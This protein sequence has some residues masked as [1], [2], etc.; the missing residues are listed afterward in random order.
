MEINKMHQTGT[1][2]ITCLPGWLCSK[3]NTMYTREGGRGK[4]GQAEVFV[5]VISLL[6]LC[7]IS[8]FFCFVFVLFSHGYL[9]HPL[10]LRRG[11]VLFEP[12]CPSV[13]SGKYS[14]GIKPKPQASTPWNNSLCH[15][16]EICH[17]NLLNF[18]TDWQRDKSSGPDAMCLFWVM[19]SRLWWALWPFNQSPEWSSMKLSTHWGLLHRGLNSEKLLTVEGNESSHK[20]P[21]G[22]LGSSGLLTL[23]ENTLLALVSSK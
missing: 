22:H 3:C 11:G 14:L 20:L 13:C 9:S 2:P 1:V 17:Y 5:S 15:S 4:L 12:K 23:M 7:C 8:A 21:F 10:R 18:K 19:K 6:C 16:S